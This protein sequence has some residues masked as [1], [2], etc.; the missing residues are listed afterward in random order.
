MVHSIRLLERI[1]FNLRWILA[2]ACSLKRLVNG[3]SSRFMVH[4][5]G[6][7]EWS[8]ETN[9]NFRH[10]LLRMVRDNTIAEKRETQMCSMRSI[11]LLVAFLVASFT[12]SVSLALT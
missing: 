7:H 3:G 1:F 5:L 11:G 12:S 9:S 4:E 8:C 6:V 2:L 10:P